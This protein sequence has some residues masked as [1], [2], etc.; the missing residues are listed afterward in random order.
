M[1]RL[2]GAVF[3]VDVEAGMPL[4]WDLLSGVDSNSGD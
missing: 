1:D 4:T 2:G 3:A